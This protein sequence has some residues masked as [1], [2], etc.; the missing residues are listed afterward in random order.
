MALLFVLACLALDAIT[1]N[2]LIKRGGR[3]RLS[4]WA[5]G[6][7]PSP[8]LVWGWVFAFPAIVISIVLVNMPQLTWFAIAAGA[9]RLIMA[10]RNHRLMR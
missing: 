8:L 7:H 2:A 4:A 10:A 5:I 6:E 1:T 9:F 3:E